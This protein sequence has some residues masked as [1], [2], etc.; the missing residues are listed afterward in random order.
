MKPR[1]R[2]PLIPADSNDRTGSAGLRRQALADIG[3]RFAALR[4]EVLAIF[5]GIRT[6]QVNDDQAARDLPAE[7]VAAAG[8]AVVEDA[9]AAAL[10]TAART[11]YAMTPDELS[12]VSF[13]LRQALDRWIAS[14]REAAH[15]FWWSP[16]VAQASQKGAAQASAALSRLS[17][18]YAS[19]RSLQQILFSAPYRN[20][21]AMAQIKSYE[22]WTGL[23]AQLKAELSQL[24]GAAVVDG[25]NP[26]AVRTEIAERL[27]VGKSKAAQYAQTDI[28]DTLRQARMQEDEAAELELGLVTR[29]LWTSAFKATTRPSHAARSGRA[30][31]RE[32]VRDFYSRDGNRY[33]CFCSITTCL[34][35]ADGQPIISADAKRKLKAEREAWQKKHLP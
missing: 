7:A 27:D 16:Y 2:Y 6:L 10:T 34:V 11:V 18:A 9:E 23:S 29:E 19:A 32:E 33:N 28:T 1:V 8:V 17:D 5:D 30:Y 24:I 15:S 22:H 21:V 12:S 4:A 3:R 26:R 35:D 25:K 13:A 20:R 31:T 14:G